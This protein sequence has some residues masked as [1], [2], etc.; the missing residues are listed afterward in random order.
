[1][2]SRRTARTMN[3]AGLVLGVTAVLGLLGC[4][5]WLI[6]EGLWST[7]G[8][9]WSALLLVV[10]YPLATTEPDVDDEDIE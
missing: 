6:Y 8:L 5:A 7:L 2:A 3:I 9:V 10:A 4:T 1:M